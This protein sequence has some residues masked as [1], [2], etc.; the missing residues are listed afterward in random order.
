VSEVELDLIGKSARIL[1]HPNCGT[2]CLIDLPQL[3]RLGGILDELAGR[4]DLERVI[5]GTARAD[6]VLSGPPPERFAEFAD[7]QE[8]SSYAADGQRVLARLAALGPTTIAFLSGHVLSGGLELAL[9]CD[10]RLASGRPGLRF[11]FSDALIGL[12]PAWGGTLRLTRLLG[13][14]LALEMLTRSIAADA[15][16][17][18][19]W[20]LVDGVAGEDELLEVAERLG[21]PRS[22]SWPPIDRLARVLPPLRRLVFDRA[23]KRAACGGLGAPPELAG[24]LVRLVELALIWSPDE[25]LAQEARAFAEGIHSREARTVREAFLAHPS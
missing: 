24:R 3:E 2:R 18:S 19:A 6:M 16:R 15:A 4:S 5:L 25:V 11:G 10:L 13:P 14:T 20:G 17:A 12:S 21:S 7:A 9:A 1:F 8:A 23:A 22:Q